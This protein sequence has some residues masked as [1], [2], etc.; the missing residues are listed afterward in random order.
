MSERIEGLRLL[1]A[2]MLGAL[3]STRNIAAIHMKARGYTD[4]QIAASFPET[5]D[6]IAEA[7][8]EVRS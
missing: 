2:R 6:V 8:A 7:E 4:L 3:V 1:V 5:E